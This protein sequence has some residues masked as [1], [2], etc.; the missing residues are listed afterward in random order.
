MSN[1]KFFFILG[2]DDAE[3]SL[4]AALLAAF[5]VRFSQ[6]NKGWGDHVF[7]PEQVGLETGS[8]PVNYG[9]GACGS[10]PCVKNAGVCG[11]FPGRGLAG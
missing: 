3:M 6:P 10:V 4:I 2:G 5:G 7:Q 9:Y 1:S 8:Y 11:M